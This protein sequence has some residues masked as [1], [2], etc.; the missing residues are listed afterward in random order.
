M[1]YYDRQQYGPAFDYLIHSHNLSKELGFAK[2]P[3]LASTLVTTGL[4]YYRF[5]EYQAALEH[6]REVIKLLEHW[7]SPWSATN[8]LN[9]TGLCFQQLMQY[10]SAAHY[11]A[12]ASDFAKSALHDTV[13]S[14]IIDGN[15][16][17]AYQLMGK[18]EQA[19]AFIRSRLSI[20]PNTWGDW[21]CNQCSYR[22]GFNLP[23]EKRPGCR[24]EVS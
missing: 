10:D 15:R 4:I 1:H 23:G 9:S 5:G 18:M 3:Q 22:P 16:A 11:F 20:Q 7:A 24:A 8:V 21:Q 14:I 2:Y 13:Y 19:I 17:K 6:F 12:M